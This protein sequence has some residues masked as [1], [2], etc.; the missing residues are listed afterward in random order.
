M[1]A[2]KIVFSPKLLTLSIM[3]T[4]IATGFF[5]PEALS[6]SVD[7]LQVPLYGPPSSFDLRD[8]NGASYVTAIRHQSGG[9]CWCFGAMAAIESN[10]LMT[11][12]WAAAGETG[13]PDLAEYHLDWWN[14]F[15]QHN[16]DDT[17][18]TTGGGLTVHQGGDYMVTS[19]YL[20]RGEG[21]IREIDAP[22]FD[23]PGERYSPSYHYYYVRDI[24]W[25][26]A[27]SD[28]ENIDTI[29]Q[30][31]MTHGAVGTCMRVTTF[32]ENVTH[33]Y[34]GSRDPTHAIAIIGWDDNKVTKA[35]EPGAWLCKNSW[36]S[37]WGLDG[38]FWI[39]YYDGHAGQDPEMGAVSFQNVEPMPYQYIYYHDY[40]GW[41][42]TKKHCTE[43]FNAFT[44][45]DRGLLE[46][47]SF[48]TA[49]DNVA[50]TVTIYDTF[51][52]GSLLN[53]LATHSGV[54]TYRGFHTIELDTPVMVIPDDDFYLYLKLS[55]GGHP[56]DCTSEV[57]VLLGAANTS[58]TI[59]ES[60]SQPGQSYYRHESAWVDL[61]E[62][63]ETANFCIK[64]LIANE[65]D[66][67]CQGSLGWD[68][69]KPGSE[70]TGSFTV[71]NAGE[72]FSKLDWEIIDYPSWGTWSFTPST[73]DDLTPEDGL[74]TIEVT[75]AIP[76]DQGQD[77]NGELRIVN[78]ANQSDYDTIQISVT[79]P[80]N[81]NLLYTHALQFF[82]HLLQRFPL[83]KARLPL[84]E[85]ILLHPR[86]L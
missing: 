46:A 68:K 63:D 64:G 11:G 62:F 60:S 54:I 65:A 85:D 38:Y 71:Q 79:T 59:V 41:R 15:N 70:A 45:V 28:L 51:E 78:K 29:K 57:P 34:D 50:Y 58:G 3:A 14:G 2:K 5:V 82:Q 18:P 1:L 56:Y 81:K 72:Q 24:E 17:T 19:A 49:A 12:N 80:I 8:Y 47:V 13:E 39:S 7:Q 73:G 69:V 43:A 42:D 23:E 22:Y 83:L 77:Y 30:T 35:R 52:D 27:G 84:L 44:A 66:L 74:T 6:T 33:W 61:Y 20:S 76:D 25:H 32:D 36:G 53:Q 75:V 10:L 55:A 67:E 21:A 9:T 37:G 26:I 16:N 40:H 31:V 48:F 86:L 4:M